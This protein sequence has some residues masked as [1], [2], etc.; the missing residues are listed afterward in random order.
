MTRELGRFG[1]SFERIP[2]VDGRELSGGFI[3]ENVAE[4]NSL[5]K[6]R[7]PRELSPGEIG[8]MLGHRKAWETFLKAKQRYG[9]FLEDDVRFSERARLYLKYPDWIPED[10]HVIQLYGN[11]GVFRVKEKELKV[12]NGEASL[13]NCVKPFPYGALAYILDREAAEVAF[14][15]SL[16]VITNAD[17]YLFEKMYWLA[18]RY[19]VWSLSPAVAT[20][21]DIPTD[22]GEKGGAKRSSLLV[23]NSPARLLRKMLISLE[24]RRSRRSVRIDFN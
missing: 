11:G 6:W 9:L 13:L 20:V 8:C 16:P 12:Q 10:V 7:C 21:T 5:Q 23:R 18:C 14:E 2:G 17:A 19:D 4:L 22:I 1:L 15:H 24:R 3:R